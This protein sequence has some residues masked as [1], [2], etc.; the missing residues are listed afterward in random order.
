MRAHISLIVAYLNGN[1]QF[2]QNLR[3]GREG[4]TDEMVEWGSAPGYDKQN[5]VVN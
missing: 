2:I 3:P 4:N 5:C 1:K